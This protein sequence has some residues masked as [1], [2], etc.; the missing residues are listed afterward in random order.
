[1]KKKA[2]IFSTFICLITFSLSLN[3]SSIKN[4]KSLNPYLEKVHHEGDLIIQENEI[5]I[6]NYQEFTQHGNVKIYGKLIIQNSKFTMQL[7]YHEEFSINLFGNGI[8]EILDSNVDS[9]YCFTISLNENSKCKII[10]TEVKNSFIPVGGN[11]ELTIINLP[12]T[13][14]I[15]LLIGH[16]AYAESDVTK[17]YVED[18]YVHELGFW[19]TANHEIE[20]ANIKENSL[21]NFDIVPAANG[22]AP[23]DIHFKNTRIFVFDIAA[24]ENSKF[25]IINSEIFSIGFCGNSNQCGYTENSTITNIALFGG[26][27][28]NLQFDG[29]KKGY[30]ENFDLGEHGSGFNYRVQMIRTTIRDG[31]TLKTDVAQETI[32]KNSE[33]SCLRPFSGTYKV[34]DSVLKEF[35]SYLFGYNSAH[36]EV[37]WNNS[38]IK[39]WTNHLQC[40]FSFKGNIE[41]ESAP[42]INPGMGPC[43]EAK[44]K[45]EFPVWTYSGSN[46]IAG[47][48]LQVLDPQENEIWSGYSDETGEAFFNIS[49]DC[50]NYNKEYTLQS[51]YLGS[52]IKFKLGSSTPLI[53]PRYSLI[54][55]SD[56][57]GIT[58]PEAGT[59]TYDPGKEVTITATPNSGYEFSGWSGDASGTANPI[60]IK[61]D[62]NKSIK[63]NFSAIPKTE[64][65]SE[66][67][68]GPCF[69][70]TAAYDSPSH[71]HVNILR[72]FRDKYLI[73]SKLGRKLV[74]LYYKYSPF[75]AD[76]IAKHKVL[77]VAVRI[78]LLPLVAFSYSMLYFGPTITAV[79]GG[80]IFLFSAFL[81]WCFQRKHRGDRRRTKK[82]N[83]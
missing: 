80:F 36:A 10:N 37:I 1:M 61:M 31:W 13:S 23:F 8:I 72:D 60:T 76:S 68:K 65:E 55:T 26:G 44:V 29:L 4:S 6:I 20:L 3:F 42:L 41:I 59:Y 62:S 53:I 49:F 46:R 73:P 67:K 35:W 19:L 56:I 45:R 18:S 32:I 30:L 17:I 11:I 77:K 16:N 9:S 27:Y 75:V 48:D 66:E 63:A 79:V 69:I 64:D 38:T 7:A 54:L 52:E 22:K 14:H 33:L 39:K 2:S 83:D 82:Q 15:N 57:G 51:Q 43:L 47:V 25:R 71:P 40:D 28:S 81:I 24:L 21:N 74:Y 70:A 5:F 12:D 34:Y 58:D 50:S 78:N